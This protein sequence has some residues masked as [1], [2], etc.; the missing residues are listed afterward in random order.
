[1]VRGERFLR[2]RRREVGELAS[3]RVLEVAIGTGLSLPWYPRDGSVKSVTGIELAPSMLAIARSRADQLELPFP[4]EL[5]EADAQAL[6]FEAASFD[7]AVFNLCLCTIP[8]PQLAIAEA[9][10]C[11]R[12]GGRVVVME[13]VRSPH[14]PVWAVQA[15]VDPLMVWLQGDHFTRRTEAMFAA[16]GVELEILERWFLG[17]FMLGAGR[18]PERLP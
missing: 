17:V 11:L 6:P 8:E 14:W 13:H 12:P 9:V 4:V 3:G 10:R 2:L 7:S 1:M 15:A 16:A 5:L 18:I